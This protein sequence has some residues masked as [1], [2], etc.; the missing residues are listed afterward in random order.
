MGTPHRWRSKARPRQI[1]LVAG[2]HHLDVALFS[3]TDR[4]SFVKCRSFLQFRRENKKPCLHAV[5]RV[6]KS[7]FD[8]Y[9]LTMSL[10]KLVS[11]FC[12]EYAMDR[13]RL[14]TQPWL[15]RLWRVAF[16]TDIVGQLV[17]DMFI[18]VFIERERCLPHINSYSQCIF[19][20]NEEYIETIYPDRLIILKI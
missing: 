19:C 3:F 14:N 16:A 5:S 12:P 11:S 6:K 2:R 18:Q 15:N 1:Q 20:R 10:S 4:S 13:P 9:L 7:Y 8:R 17:V